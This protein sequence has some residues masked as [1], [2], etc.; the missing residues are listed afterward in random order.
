MA[1]TSRLGAAMPQNLPPTSAVAEA[2]EDHRTNLTVATWRWQGANN[3]REQRGKTLRQRP[4]QEDTRGQPRSNSNCVVV[5]TMSLSS[6]TSVVD[7]DSVPGSAGPASQ[8]TGLSV[9]HFPV[10][11]I[12]LAFV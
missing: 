3:W 10:R 11:V 8:L 5:G 7:C 12:P 1:H 6:F 4:Q 9:S 2:T